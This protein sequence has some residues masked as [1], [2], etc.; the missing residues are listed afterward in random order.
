MWIYGNPNNN[1]KGAPHA[2]VLTSWNMHSSERRRAMAAISIGCAL[3]GKIKTWKRFPQE[4][5]G[6]RRHN[7]SRGGKEKSIMSPMTRSMLPLIPSDSLKLIHSLALMPRRYKLCRLYFLMVHT[8]CGNWGVIS[9]AESVRHPWAIVTNGRM[10]LNNYCGKLQRELS[11]IVFSAAT[12][13]L[14]LSLKGR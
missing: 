11:H 1:S 8:L 6:K 7:R 3:S 5:W 14:K 13:Q 10:K 12:S 2:N 4:L 9:G